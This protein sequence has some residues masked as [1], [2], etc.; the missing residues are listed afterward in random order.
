MGF[1]FLLGWAACEVV[2]P[3]GENPIGP[4]WTLIMLI[5]VMLFAT[6]T[7]SGEYARGGGLPHVADRGKRVRL[8]VAP[9]HREDAIAVLAAPLVPWAWTCREPTLG[10]PVI[11]APVGVFLWSAARLA[12]SVVVFVGLVMLLWRTP[13]DGLLL[14]GWVVAVV[15]GLLVLVPGWRRVTFRVEPGRLRL[16]RRGWFGRERV[17]TL[18]L[19]ASQV[20]VDG[21]RGLLRLRHEGQARVV[22]ISPGEVAGALA[23]ARAATEAP[24]W[25]SPSP[26]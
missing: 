9:K 11:T 5:M 1:V 26:E 20:E 19:D 25:G 8:A 16:I 24:G 4:E 6:V 15:L 13:S 22:S 12:V 10:V 23:I 7:D 18:D 14:A 17:W 2:L 3:R 21:R